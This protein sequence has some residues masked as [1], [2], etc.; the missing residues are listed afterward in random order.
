MAQQQAGF[1]ELAPIYDSLRDWTMR[2]YRQMWMRIR[3]FWT[4][5]RYIRVTDEM[6]APQFIA[7]NQVVG[8]QPAIDP[9]TGQVVMQPVIEN[10]LASLD[11][12]IVIEDA[13][14]MVSL[15]QEQFEQLTQMAQA[16]IPIPQE[17]VIEASSLRNKRKV[18]DAMDKTKQEQAQGQEQAMGMQ[19]Q[20]M[21]TEDA[22]RNAETQA[23]A[24]AAQAK[25]AK[26]L[27]DAEATQLDTSITAREIAAR[28]AVLGI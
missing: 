1:A 20:A 4:D 11:V 15:R 27:A 12:D 6:Q 21:Q 18:L 16:G 26:D 10:G 2:C 19:A 22:R 7:V 14:D 25:A 8:M 5:E 17:M 23:K 13:P 9:Q 3:Q 28:A 24:I